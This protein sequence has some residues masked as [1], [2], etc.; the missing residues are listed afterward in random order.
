MD[1]LTDIV[2]MIEIN[3][4]SCPCVHHSRA[5]GSKHSVRHDF[6]FDCA[7]LPPTDFGQ[8]VVL[9]LPLLNLAIFILVLL[10]FPRSL[11][12]GMRDGGQDEN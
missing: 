5:F 11:G 4:V 10:A 2:S 12:H 3:S 6:A 7:G 9:Y 8:V 1:R